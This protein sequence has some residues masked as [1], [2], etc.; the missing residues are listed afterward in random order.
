M[1][2]AFP[3][4][5]V[6]TSP[7]LTGDAIGPTCPI[8][9][10]FPTPIVMARQRGAALILVLWIAVILGLLMVGVVTSL[11]LENRQSHYDLQRSS[12]LLAAEGG[13]NMAVK[14][15]MSDEDSLGADGGEHSFDL[16]GIRVTL[17]VRS[18]HGKLD[19]NFCRLEHFSNLLRFMGATAQQS[20]SLT[21]QLSERRVVAKPLRDLEELL[22]VT[23]ISVDLYQQIQPYITLWSGRG[24]PDPVF[25]ASPLIQAL[26]LEVPLGVVSNPGSVISIESSAELADGFKTRLL[27]TVAL[28]SAQE[29]GGLYRVYRWQE[30]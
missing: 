4:P 22:D 30:R 7:Y 16:D 26:Q 29:R 27:A 13:V 25:A 11:R 15:L 23:S 24:V 3:H 12:A 14:M 19:L 20:A 6:Q 5:S 21:K 8:G 18:E 28:R 9:I 17:S 10:V 1:R 2:S